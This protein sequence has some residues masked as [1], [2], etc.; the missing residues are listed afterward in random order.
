M[1]QLDFDTHPLTINLEFHASGTRV[2]QSAR[3]V[4]RRANNSPC[5]YLQPSPMQL[6]A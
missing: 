6:E 1:V 2:E 3:C 5:L 4:E